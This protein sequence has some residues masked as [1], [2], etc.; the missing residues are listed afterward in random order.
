MR[1]LTAFNVPPKLLLTDLLERIFEVSQVHLRKQN[2]TCLSLHYI[3]LTF[4]IES[5]TQSKTSLS[6]S[7]I[8]LVQKKSNKA[9]SLYENS[10][11]GLLRGVKI[12]GGAIDANGRLINEADKEIYAEI[13]DLHVEVTTFDRLTRKPFVSSLC[14]DRKENLIF[15]LY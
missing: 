8:M 6:E 13:G 3:L 9:E 7:A 10:I 4:L 11:K 14:N 5:S 2:G 12:R 1:W 15:Q